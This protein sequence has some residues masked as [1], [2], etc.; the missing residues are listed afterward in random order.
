MEIPSNIGPWLVF[1]AIVI[2]VA[3]QVP[4]VI[5]DSRGPIP[6]VG[7]APDDAEP[8]A[9]FLP[10]DDGLFTW[11]LELP[12]KPRGDA[13]PQA[14]EPASVDSVRSVDAMRRGGDRPG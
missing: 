4:R 13:D 2:L 3:R 10:N 7:E 8:M 11:Y 1:A 9:R 6:D 5:R 12:E 14:G